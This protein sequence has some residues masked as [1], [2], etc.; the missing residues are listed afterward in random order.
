MGNVKENLLEGIDD[1]HKGIGGKTSPMRAQQAKLLL[2][3]N[4]RNNFLYSKGYQGKT[5]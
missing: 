4:T 5:S 3:V 2:R 1:A